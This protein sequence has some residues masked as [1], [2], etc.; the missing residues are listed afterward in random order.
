MMIAVRAN[1]RT[2]QAASVSSHGALKVA[3]NGG[4][5][6]G[7]LVVALGLLSVG[8]FYMV[9]KSMHPEGKH[10]IDSLIGLALG[11]SLI[12]VFARLGGGIYTK[13]ADV[14]AD[15][16]GK[17]EQNLNEDDPRNP[18]TIADNVGDNV[19]DCAGMAADV[20]ETYAVS[21]IGGVLVGALTAGAQDANAAVIYPFVL[22]GLSI[23]S[24]IIGIGWV[25]FVKQTPTTALVCG[26]AVSGLISA[27]LFW[28]A[29]QAIFGATVSL[30]G[31]SIASSALFRWPRDD[32]ARRLD[33]QLLH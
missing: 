30:N 13:A 27:G 12:S 10:A 18:A 17:I 25:N 9:V 33:H 5:V 29:T 21:L 3:F 28:W 11:S 16:V 23:I 2:A 24:S 19:G 22:C 26:V 1:V 15:L 6:T 7:L 4:A 31:V 32:A 8:V 20:F 14:G